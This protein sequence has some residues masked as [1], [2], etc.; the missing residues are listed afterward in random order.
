MLKVSCERMFSTLKFIEK[1]LRSRLSESKLEAFMLTAV[2]KNTLYYYTDTDGIINRLASFSK[3]KWINVSKLY[4]C[5][6]KWK[7]K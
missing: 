7:E 2:E 1:Q 5:I 3:T 6:H 4:S